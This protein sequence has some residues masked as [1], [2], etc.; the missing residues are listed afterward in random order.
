MIHHFASAVSAGWRRFADWLA[1][2][3]IGPVPCSQ[4]RV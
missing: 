2:G 4:C 1:H 3:Q